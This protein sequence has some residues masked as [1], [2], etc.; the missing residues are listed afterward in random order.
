VVGAGLSGLTV[1][2]RLRAWGKRVAVI[3]RRDHLGGLCATETDA[4]TGIEVHRHGTHVFH[5]D[6][7]AVAAYVG[8]FCRLSA[9]RHRVWARCG[10]ATYPLPINLATI[11][12]VHGL[13]LTPRQAAGLIKILTT[14]YG[15][16]EVLEP[17]T[18]VRVLCP[19]RPPGDATERKRLPRGASPSNLREAAIA[20][21]G[22]RLYELIV[23]G[24]SKKQWGADPAELP[25]ALAARIPV[26]TDYFADYFADRWQG[27]PDEGYAALFR[28][29]AHGVEV[30][31]GTAFDEVRGLVPAGCT[32]VWTGPLDAWFGYRHGRLAWRGVRLERET[33]PVSD[34]QGAAV[35]NHCDEA[36]P[37]TR[38]HEFAHLRPERRR[39]KKTVIAREYPDA[40]AEPAY[41]A[42]PDGTLAGV[43]RAAAAHEPGVVFCGRLATYRYLDM[44]EAVGQALDCAEALCRE[45]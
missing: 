43:Y 28:R 9:Y 42:D 41:P 4:E 20:K 30:L 44:D 25:A 2:E 34:Y 13:E 3:D 17:P 33:V 7:P 45:S 39:G 1:A 38:V 36:V 21:M 22:V 16:A 27:L 8:R 15:P 26:R 19:P 37:Y 32:V 23:E 11:N 29:M 24:Y 10:R 35:I 31:A 40:G 18:G 14:T 5:T 12:A 6:D